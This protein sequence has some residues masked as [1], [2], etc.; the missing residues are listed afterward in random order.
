MQ[1]TLRAFSYHFVDNRDEL[2]QRLNAYHRAIAKLPEKLGQCTYQFN[3]HRIMTEK[4]KKS[5][6]HIDGTVSKPMADLSNAS[7]EDFVRKQWA[8]MLAELPNVTG[9]F[10]PNRS[11]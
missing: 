2:M 4:R 3:L 10:L 5:L 6:H 9:K 11:L 8:A 1:S 7:R